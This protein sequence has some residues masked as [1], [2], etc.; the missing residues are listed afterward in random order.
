MP[1][2]RRKG[3]SLLDGED[4]FESGAGGYIIHDPELDKNQGMPDFLFLRESGIGIGSGQRTA[5]SGWWAVGSGQR[6]HLAVHTD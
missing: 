4:M 1:G 2:R 5:G 6:E 3:G